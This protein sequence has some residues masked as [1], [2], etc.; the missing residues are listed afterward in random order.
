MNI[1]GYVIF[2][3]IC[4]FTL[5]LLIDTIIWITKRVKAKKRERIENKDVDKSE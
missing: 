5:W 3:I 1:V 2:A 4:A